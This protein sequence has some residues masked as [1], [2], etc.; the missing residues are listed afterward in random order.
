MTLEP[1][2]H[3]WAKTALELCSLDKGG[4]ISFLFNFNSLSNE[5]QIVFVF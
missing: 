4:S 3:I 2:V 1:T 5:Y